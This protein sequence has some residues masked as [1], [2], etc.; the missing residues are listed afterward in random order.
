MEYQGGRTSPDDL[1]F[2]KYRAEE[3]VL[4][5]PTAYTKNTQTAEVVNVAHPHS[6]NPWADSKT[7]ECHCQEE[8]PP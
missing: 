8:N 2:L 6:M 5:A 7:T 3:R 1:P 4:G